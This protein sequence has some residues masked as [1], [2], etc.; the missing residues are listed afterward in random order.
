M[1]MTYLQIP[2]QMWQHLTHLKLLL[3]NDL[4]VKVWLYLLITVHSYLGVRHCHAMKGES[5]NIVWFH[6]EYVRWS[7]LH[8]VW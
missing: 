1:V 8:I 5:Y 7:T 6:G 4:A 2:I 3:N